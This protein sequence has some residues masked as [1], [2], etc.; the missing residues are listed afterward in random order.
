M[1][2]A[3]SLQHEVIDLTTDDDDDVVRQF[4]P[5]RTAPRP[6]IANG[7]ESPP[8]RGSAYAEPPAPSRRLA[9]EQPL[10]PPHAYST[11]S[12]GAPPPAKRQKL[13]EPPRGMG[14]AEQVITKSVGIHLYSFA[15]DAVEAF[16]NTGVDEDKLRAEVGQH[17]QDTVPVLSH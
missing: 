14:Y 15:R 12:Y 11:P 6:A 5:L 17:L 4:P 10:H 3:P 1:E 7:T 9:P 16:K 13:S 2:M 8:I